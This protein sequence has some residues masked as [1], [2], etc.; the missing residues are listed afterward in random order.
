MRSYHRPLIVVFSSLALASLFSYAAVELTEP[1]PKPTENGVGICGGVEQ[2]RVQFPGLS[3]SKK[4]GT[5]G[6]SGAARN[7]TE[8]KLPKS[9]G[10]LF[11]GEGQRSLRSLPNAEQLKEIE[12]FKKANIE[13]FGGDPSKLMALANFY[14]LGIGT[15]KDEI[16]AARIHLIGANKGDARCQFV[17]G[18]EL[19]Q[20]QGVKKDPAAG[21]TWIHKA[22]DQKLPDA[23]YL[24]HETYAAGEVV[25]RDQAEARKWLLRAAEHGHHEARADLAEEILEEKDRKRAKSVLMWVQAGALAG[26][27]RSCYIMGHVYSVGF[28]VNADPVES[29]AWRLVLLNI[30]DEDNSSSW[31]IDYFGLGEADQAKAEKRAKELSGPRA[32]LSPFARNP[33][34][35]IAEKKAFVATKLEA[36]KGDLIAQHRLAVFYHLGRGTEK[37]E[38]EAIRW[39][40]KSAEQGLSVAQFTLGQSLR[41]GEGVTPDLKEAF[42]WFMKAAAQGNANAEHAVSVCYQQGDG[43]KADE[44]E[45]RKWRR[46]AAEHGEPRA[47]CNLG[48]D[49]Y[50]EQP[51]IAKDAIAARWFRKA[52]EQ[53]HPKGGF[54]LGLCYLTGRGVPQDKIE[55]LAWMFTSADGLAP[56]YKEALIR[57]VDEFTEDEIKEAMMRRKQL[58]AECRAKLKSS[59][60]SR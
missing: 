55:G 13:A 5:D 37:D 16:E 3:E 32:Y 8:E 30:E 49:H 17:H 43:V 26:H 10:L 38:T 59:A 52:A 47:Q 20:G 31:K 44:E 1:E 41:L 54:S 15:E 50:G 27:A 24:L 2:L 33:E 45:A 58:A 42:A 14:L 11:C 39:C 25:A 6:K 35:V 51:D 19:I 9:P 4:I 40:R 48:N 18:C 29:M 53:F 23:E 36:E 7:G 57:V 12:A 22:A 28:G 46:L 60:A 21:L 56:E 34:D